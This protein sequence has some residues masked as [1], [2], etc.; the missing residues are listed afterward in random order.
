MSLL[1][2]R[3]ITDILAQTYDVKKVVGVSNNIESVVSTT[4]FT[5]QTTEV[6]PLSISQQ[7]DNMMFP[8]V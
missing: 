4:T 1:S 2:E 8:N 7:Q 3:T 5:T 6:G